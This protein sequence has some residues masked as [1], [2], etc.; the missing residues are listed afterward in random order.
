MRTL[1]IAMVALLSP[2]VSSAEIMVGESAE[3]LAHTSDLIAKATPLE[4][5]AIKGQVWFTQVRCRLED[6]VK[7]PATAGDVVTIYDYSFDKPD[8]LD[9]TGAAKKGRLFLLFAAVSKNRYSEIEGKFVLTLQ[10]TPRSAF[11]LDEAVKNLYT[12][13]SQRLTKIEDLLTRA[14]EQVRR[15]EEFQCAYPRGCVEEERRESPWDSPAYKDLYS[16]SSVYV[17]SPAY[18]NAK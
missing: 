15:E 13:D 12:P 9:L 6:V 3:W 18:R 10:P 14:R 5:R 7:G 2:L 4:V 1:L 16:G 8:P 17:F 11:F